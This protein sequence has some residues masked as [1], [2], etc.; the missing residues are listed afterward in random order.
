MRLEWLDISWGCTE[1][2]GCRNLFNPLYRILNSS[3][4][5]LI[6]NTPKQLGT[7]KI[8][9]HGKGDMYFSRFFFL[10]L[11]FFDWQI[12]ILKECFVLVTIREWQSSALRKI[13]DIDYQIMFTEILSPANIWNELDEKIDKEESISNDCTAY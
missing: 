9:S 11:E 7:F 4:F 1:T 10:V 3:V 5:L 2:C 6:T 13:F 12:V 8:I